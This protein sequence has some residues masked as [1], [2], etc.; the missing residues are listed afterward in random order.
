MTIDV[1]NATFSSW[2]MTGQSRKEAF[3]ET[4]SKHSRSAHQ[5]VQREWK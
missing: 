5:P 4:Y 1:K 3:F 2:F